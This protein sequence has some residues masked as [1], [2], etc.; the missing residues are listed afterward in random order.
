MVCTM[1]SSPE[2][3]RVRYALATPVPRG[4]AW[5]AKDEALARIREL[6]AE[7]AARGGR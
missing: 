5:P 2:L 1:R 4:A 7:L 3:P 6:E